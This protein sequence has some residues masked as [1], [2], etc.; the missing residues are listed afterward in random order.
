MDNILVDSNLFELVAF[1]ALAVLLFLSLLIVGGL[2]LSARAF[3]QLGELVALIAQ[4]QAGLA[5]R[6]VPGR[7]VSS[8]PSGARPGRD[9]PPPNNPDKDV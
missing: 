6:V 5:D 7:G 1:L 8:S 9:S 3:A 2:V 4:I